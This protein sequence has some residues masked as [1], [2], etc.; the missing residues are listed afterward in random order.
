MRWMAFDLNTSLKNNFRNREH[1][2]ETEVPECMMLRKTT[3]MHKNPKKHE[4]KQQLTNNV[5]G[6]VM[7]NSDWNELIRVNHRST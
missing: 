3:V 2:C 7:E 6:D 1:C 4:H 5:S